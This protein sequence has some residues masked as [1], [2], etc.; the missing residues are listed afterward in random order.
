MK[1]KL[2]LQTAIKA[3]LKW[4]RW[5]GEGLWGAGRELFAVLNIVSILLIR[6]FMVSGERMC[7]EIEKWTHWNRESI[8]DF[9][10]RADIWQFF[11][12]VLSENSE[13]SLEQWFRTAVLTASHVVPHCKLVHLQFLKIDVNILKYLNHLDYFLTQFFSSGGLCHKTFSS[14]GSAAKFIS[15]LGSLAH[16]IE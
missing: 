11:L 7:K 14:R 15:I 10:Y 9:R 16:G 1:R 3:L 12:F 2:S 6:V 5:E 13:N 4:V 8:L